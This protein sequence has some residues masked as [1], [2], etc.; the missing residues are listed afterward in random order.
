MSVVS[1]ATGTTKVWT[2]FALLETRSMCV[3]RWC[4]VHLV[5]Y[6]MLLTSRGCVT[7][8]GSE[9][10]P[11]EAQTCSIT[12]KTTSKTKHPLDGGELLPRIAA[13]HIDLW[14]GYLNVAVHNSFA[15]CRWSSSPQ[16]RS[17]CIAI[18]AIRVGSYSPWSPNVY[19]GPE[20]PFSVAVSPSREVRIIKIYVRCI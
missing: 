19:D 10:N 9:S 4:N 5:N 1:Y 2:V 12:F 15:L 16:V 13:D 17:S 6:D 7:D 8:G 20:Y 11:Q 3:T 18:K 14:F